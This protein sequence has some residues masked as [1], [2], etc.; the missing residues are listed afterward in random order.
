MA[1]TKK[2]VFFMHFWGGGGGQNCA[3]NAIFP[4]P[5]PTESITGAEFPHQNLCDYKAR[6]IA[7]QPR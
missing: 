5:I 2:P 1:T 3:L 4:D 7:K 6:N